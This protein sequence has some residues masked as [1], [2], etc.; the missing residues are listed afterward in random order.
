MQLEDI[1]RKKEVDT[2]DILNVSL[3]G[4]E[5]EGIFKFLHR[6][7]DATH[8]I[9]NGFIIAD[10]VRNETGGKEVEIYRLTE[11]YR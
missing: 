5:E 11:D 4:I 9:P 10:W 6:Y 1:R 2:V 8:D 7:E 3:T